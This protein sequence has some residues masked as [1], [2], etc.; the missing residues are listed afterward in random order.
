MVFGPKTFLGVINL[1]LGHE[2]VFLNQFF[3]L[4]QKPSIM[5][6]VLMPKR[7]ILGTGVI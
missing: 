2:V 6:D 1:K 3:V 5:Q 7:L 4:V